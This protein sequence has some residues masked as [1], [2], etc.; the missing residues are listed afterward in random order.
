MKH[1]LPPL[2]YDYNA[3]EPYN[4]EETVRLHHDKHH[5]A[6]VNGLNTA[7]QKLEEARAAGDFALILDWEKQLAFHGSGRCLAHDVLGEYVAQWRRG[8]QGGVS[9]ADQER[10]RR[11]RSFQEAVQR[12]RRRSRRQRVGHT[13]LDA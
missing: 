2:P 1:E 12:G 6:Y 11:V 5:A 3:L 13:G 4:D 8:A 9:R 10:L 7:E